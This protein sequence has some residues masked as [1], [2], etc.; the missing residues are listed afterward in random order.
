MPTSHQHRH[1]ARVVVGGEHHRLVAGDVGLRGEHVQAL[2]P[3][4]T[5]RG[6]EGEGGDAALGHAGDVL[7]VE[8]VEHADQHGAAFHLGQLGGAG[9]DHLQHQVGAEGLGGAA[10]RRAGGFIGTVRLAGADA[11]AALDDHLVALADQLL[12]GFRGGG[13]PRL[14]GMGLEGDTDLHS[15]ISCVIVE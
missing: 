1:E 6:L 10:D 4:G 15:R 11:G 13:N 9:R 12:D 7:V 5:R 2:R 14:T 8:G 3:R